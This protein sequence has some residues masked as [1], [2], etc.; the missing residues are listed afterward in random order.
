MLPCLQV[1]RGQPHNSRY[2]L[3]LT[4]GQRIGP[5]LK[6]PAESKH[7]SIDGKRRLP[8]RPWNR[9]GTSQKNSPPHIYEHLLLPW[10]YQNPIR[11]PRVSR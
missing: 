11:R 9:N 7:R 6:G 2:C 5:S 4:R 10:S 3:W 1:A 8:F